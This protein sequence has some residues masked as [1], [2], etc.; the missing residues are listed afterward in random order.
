MLQS[1]AGWAGVAEGIQRLVIPLKQ[2][3]LR[4]VLQVWHMQLN[5]VL[6]TNAIETA[7]ALLK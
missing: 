1:V 3:F 4:A 6:L 7:D 2:P 5:G